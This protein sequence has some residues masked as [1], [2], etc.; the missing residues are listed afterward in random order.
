MI[1][2]I[3]VDDELLIR[4]GLRDIIN[5]NDFD[6]EI[7][8][9]AEDGKDALK[10]VQQYRPDIIITDIVMPMMNGLEFINKISAFHPDTKVICISAY[11]EFEFVQKAL[12]M[13]VYDYLLKPLDFDYLMTLLEK[14]RV[15]YNNSKKMDKRLLLLEAYKSNSSTF[16]HEYLLKDLIF[17]LTISDYNMTLLEHEFANYFC[18]VSV[19]RMDN[20]GV[21][22]TKLTN[23]SM[24]TIDLTLSVTI[25]E[26]LCNFD[27]IVTFSWREPCEKIVILFDKD[28]QKLLSNSHIA[29]KKT[30]HDAED[31]HGYHFLFA[32]GSIKNNIKELSSSYNDASLAINCSYIAQGQDCDNL[33]A[34]EDY[35]RKNSHF[36]DEKVSEYLDGYNSNELSRFI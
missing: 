10:L 1:K 11:E 25:K 26:H 2:V 34:N 4:E 5:W 9:V 33:F 21:I 3:I 20:F 17:T 7:V 28:K 6:M 18:I 29:L 31:K 30:C 22:S 35:M 14:M 27:K 15:E 36:I 12:K 13:G 19:I 8:G 32:N 16:I 23:E 24:A